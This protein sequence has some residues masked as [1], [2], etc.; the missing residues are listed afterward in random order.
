MHIKKEADVI[1]MYLYFK[2]RWKRHKESFQMICP[3]CAKWQ[4]CYLSGGK[5]SLEIHH[6]CMTL[7]KKKKSPGE[8]LAAD[9]LVYAEC[10]TGVTL[11]SCIIWEAQTQ[12]PPRT[13]KKINETSSRRHENDCNIEGFQGFHSLHF[14]VFTTYNLY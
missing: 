10:N 9:F 7:L 11:S 13:S 8:D 3:K 2:G 6:L 4:V 1:T 14:K 5:H 12:C